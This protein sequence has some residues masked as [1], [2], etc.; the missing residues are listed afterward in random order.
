MQDLTP[1]IEHLF[2]WV[3]ENERS[4]LSDDAI[5]LYLGHRRS[6]DFDL[7]TSGQIKKLSIKKVIDR[8]SC[9][10]SDMSQRTLSR[11]KFDG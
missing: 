3:P 7:L 8:H 11:E 9:P 1:I 4:S 6:I 10:V 5:A 2:W